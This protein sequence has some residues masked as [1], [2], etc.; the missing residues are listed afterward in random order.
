MHRYRFSFF[1]S[2]IYK[3][4]SKYIQF[5]IDLFIYLVI[6]YGEAVCEHT[7]RVS[8]TGR[9]QTEKCKPPTLNHACSVL[10]YAVQRHL[11][12]N[13]DISRWLKLG[14]KNDLNVKNSTETFLIFAWFRSDRIRFWN[15]AVLRISTFLGGNNILSVVPDIL[16]LKRNLLTPLSRPH[17][18]CV[19][20]W[21]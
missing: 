13:M 5:F 8:T 17:K 10:P 1:M 15:N 20:W 19:P 14:I 9:G 21:S 2:V 18:N 6:N 4:K 16:Y 7:L 12:E 11:A 3:V